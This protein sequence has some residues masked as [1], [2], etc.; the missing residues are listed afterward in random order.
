MR[1]SVMRKALCL[2][3]LLV[4]APADAA[5]SERELVIDG[6]V[7]LATLRTPDGAVRPPLAIVTHGTLA[8]KDMETVV[9]L[10]KALAEKGVATLAHNLTL[11]QDRRRGMYDCATPHDHRP[12][13]AMI[14]IGAWIAE[15]RKLGYD[16]IWLVG[17][18]RGANQVARTLAARGGE[19]LAGAALLAPSTAAS[20]QKSIAAYGQT[21][22]GDLAALT[23]RAREMLAAGRGGET[24]ALPGFLYCHDAR[25]TARAFLA[26]YG[27]DAGRDTAAL[28]ERLSLPVLVLAAANDAV[29]ADVREAFAPIAARKRDLRVETIDGA[30]HFFLDL[31]GEDAADRIAAFIAGK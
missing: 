21:Y 10:S 17:H 8:H 15:A 2:I 25:A 9:T 3:A 11:G 18:S 29:V 6:R 5:E 12:D 26:V 28:A 23:A 20:E 24:M 7:A 22:G 1:K 27:A 30:D 13:D 31:A 19:G 4:A 16:R 14:E